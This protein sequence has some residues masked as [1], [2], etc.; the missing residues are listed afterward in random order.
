MGVGRWE[1]DREESM[2]LYYWTES[3]PDPST[4][5]HDIR[6][7]LGDQKE[8]PRQTAIFSHWDL[9]GEGFCFHLHTRHRRGTYNK[10]S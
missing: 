3:R 6:S 2:S 5:R 1:E 7:F 8:T 9:V 4:S 10:N